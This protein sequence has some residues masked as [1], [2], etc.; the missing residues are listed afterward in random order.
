M[1]AI[2]LVIDN[3]DEYMRHVHMGVAQSSDITMVSKAGALE[4]GRAGVV[5]SFEVRIDGKS[6]HVQAVTTL[7]NLQ[8]AIGAFGAHHGSQ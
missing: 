1:E 2:H 5:I 7:R 8:S 4:S 3:P 6:V